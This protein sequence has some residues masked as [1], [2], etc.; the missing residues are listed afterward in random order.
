MTRVIECNANLPDGENLLWEGVLTSVAHL[1]LSFE[2]CLLLH[3]EEVI[4][5]SVLPWLKVVTRE[6]RT[7]GMMCKPS[8][9]PFPPA[10]LALGG[11]PR[12]WGGGIGFA[13]SSFEPN[14]LN[15]KTGESGTFHQVSQSLGTTSV[16]EFITAKCTRLSSKRIMEVS[17]GKKEN[18]YST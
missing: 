9:P 4:R 12:F 3:Q 10:F 16:W 6:K 1:A 17:G 14:I 15:R 5:G 18:T 13:R 8:Y 7:D 2:L 11:A